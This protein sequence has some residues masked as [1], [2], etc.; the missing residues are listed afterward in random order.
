MIRVA[1]FDCCSGLT[2]IVILYTIVG[3][4][5]LI[6]V[7]RKDA[8]E[9]FLAVLEVLPHLLHPIEVLAQYHSG[10]LFLCGQ[11]VG[12]SGAIGLHQVWDT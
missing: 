12:G 1:W 8:L 10:F 11:L 4:A 7:L 5:A 9:L 2:G 6:L 3:G